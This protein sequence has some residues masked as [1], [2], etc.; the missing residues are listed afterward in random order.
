MRPYP[1]C[2]DKDKP[3]TAAYRGTEGTESGNHA[4]ELSEMTVIIGVRVSKTGLKWC[5]GRKYKGRGDK[6]RKLALKHE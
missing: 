6:R 3:Y 2:M 4:P 5:E 1:G